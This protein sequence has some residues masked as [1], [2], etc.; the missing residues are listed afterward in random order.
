MKSFDLEKFRAADV[1]L[2]DKDKLVDLREIEIADGDNKE[3]NALNFLKRIQ[4]PYLFKVGEIAVK[5]DFCGEKRLS[6]MMA[7]ALAAG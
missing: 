5:V 4:N 3:R 7:E 1:A 2:C 6:D